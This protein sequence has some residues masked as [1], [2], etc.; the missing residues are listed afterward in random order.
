MEAKL[1]TEKPDLIDLKEQQRK[2]SE[3]FG[4]VEYTWRF[5]KLLDKS[6][7]FKLG[8]DPKSIYYEREKTPPTN[9]SAEYFSQVEDKVPLINRLKQ[10]L[11]EPN[12]RGSK[13]YR[14]SQIVK[15]I[16]N[17]E[18]PPEAFV[19]MRHFG[20][21]GD[22]TKDLASIQPGAKSLV[23]KP[24]Q[25]KYR[26]LQY[27]LSTHVHEFIHR[28]LDVVP[29]LKKWKKSLKGK[30]DNEEILIGALVVKHFPQL[31]KIEKKRILD[32][33]KVDMDKRRNK[34]VLDRWV[35]QA[36]KIAKQ[37]LKTKKEQQRKASE[38]KDSKFQQGGIN[39]NKTEEQMEQLGLVSEPTNVDPVSGNEIPLGA[40]AEGV[41]DDQTA[42]ISAGEFVIPDY[43]VR[44]HGLDFYVDTLQK[45]QQGLQQMEGMG[46]VGNPDE[47]VIPDEAPLPGME[48]DDR[49][50]MQ[51][52][53]EDEAVTEQV[54]GEPAVAEFQTG[55]LSTTPLYRP[56]QQQQVLPATQI[57][58]API[59][60]N[61]SLLQKQLK[62]HI[63]RTPYDPLV[64]NQYLLN[65]LIL[66]LA[67]LSIVDL[68]QNTILHKFF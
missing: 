27:D 28:T 7:L 42:A 58:P 62:R 41:R 61:Q 50:P 54:M 18:I 15:A 46:L 8:F 9:V 68:I 38:Q 5:N 33:Y 63:R 34:K 67:G 55:G 57:A 13:K 6:P 22:Y 66:N 2:T 47:Q 32:V 19:F 49:I 14:Y 43:A 1:P 17:K 36:E 25:K 53:A 21:V 51:Q 52:M 12:I 64:L 31:A 30:V 39:M 40:T 37:A 4:D 35:N 20:L 26:D 16:E 44:Y 10:A 65:Y 3:Q 29:E 56:Q 45:A 23:T 60:L 24:E 59:L 48:E 11:Q